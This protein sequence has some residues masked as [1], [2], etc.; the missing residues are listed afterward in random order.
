MS[1]ETLQ[2]LNNQTLIGFTEKR[3]N[4]WHYAEALQGDEPNHYKG[5]VPVEDV[6]RRL[7][8]WEAVSTPL[9]VASGNPI[10]PDY[11]EIPD[12][13]A[14]IRSDT[15]DVLGIFKDG[16]QPHQ[17]DAWLVRNVEAILDAG[18][19][20]GSAGLLRS[21]AQAWVSVEVPENV[22]TPSGVVFRPQLIAA[23]SFDGSIATT[24]K[25]SATIVV[26]DNTLAAGLAGA[27]ER[28][29]LK[30]TRYSGGKVGEAREAF[31]IVYQTAEDVEAE[32]EKLLTVGVTDPEFAKVRD[33]MIPLTDAKGQPVE[34][35][36]LTVAEGK[37]DEIARLYLHD[38]RV[39]PWA[40][41]AFGV[42]QAFNTYQHHYGIVRNASRVQRN[43]SNAIG[44]EV[45]DNDAAVLKA[46][47]EVLE[48]ALEALELV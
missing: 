28:Y 27:G 21:G 13:Q 2:W 23:T 5:P 15:R 48:G 31:G 24:Y 33:I 6:R 1:R 36:K 3:G 22:I 12:R 43:R 9:F 8:G 11:V 16:Y 37:R 44:N 32:I 26:C 41:T 10:A 47:D 42:L 46:L 20:I 19:A 30:H 45:A 17:Y 38:D 18:L 29:R 39:T 4:A 7:F 34:G 25:R 40:G 35:R 14:I